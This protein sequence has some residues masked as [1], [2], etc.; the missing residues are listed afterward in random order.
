MKREW[1]VFN[2]IIFAAVCL[3]AVTTFVIINGIEDLRSI[4]LFALSIGLIAYVSKTHKQLKSGEVSEDEMSTMIRDKAGA[5]SFYM[6]LYFWFII[7]YTYDVD[8]EVLI[9]GFAGMAILFAI[10]YAVINKKGTQI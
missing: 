6:S 2:L 10:N 1:K 3:F 5:R 9:I 7:A 4:I 8:S